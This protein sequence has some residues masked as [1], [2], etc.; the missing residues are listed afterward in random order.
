MTPKIDLASW[1]AFPVRVISQSDIAEAHR[2][3]ELGIEVEE[4]HPMTEFIY[5][6]LEDILGFKGGTTTDDLP[7]VELFMKGSLNIFTIMGLEEFIAEY[8]SGLKNDPLY[9]SN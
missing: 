2:N 3:H 6:N 1:R 8:T 5:L 9:V 4:L 7:C